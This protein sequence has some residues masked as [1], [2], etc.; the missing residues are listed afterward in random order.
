MSDVTRIL[1]TVERG[2][3]TAAE[4]LLP[5][6]YDELRKLAAQKMALEPAGHT[7][8]PTALVHEAWLRLVE[9]ENQS[10]Q[11]R[12]HFFAAAAE[13]MR[14]VLIDRARSKQAARHGGGWERV[15]LEMIDAPARADEDTVLRVNDCL[16]ALARE[17]TKAAEMVKL[18]F[19]TGLS[20]E[21]AA[22]ALGV[23][24]RTGR[25]YWR[26]AR[27]WLYE[28]LGGQESGRASK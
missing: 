18:R 9:A 6:V 14:R 7:L 20:A 26:F 19:F 1:E 25:R 17:D 10:W 16:E 15:G 22:V 12:A 28:R 21:E 8:Q 23:T 3:P 11:N 5:L 27:A 13:A 4:E 24:D 2:D